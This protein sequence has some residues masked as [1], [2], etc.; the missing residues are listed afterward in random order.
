[1]TKSVEWFDF[2]NEARNL[3]LKGQLIADFHPT[4][5][6]AIEPSVDNSFFLQFVMS[7]D[8][9][10]WYRTTW[11]RLLDAPKFSNPMENLK[12]VGQEIKPTIKFEHGSINKSLL[13]DIITLVPS[14]NIPPVIDEL[15][16]ITI[17]GV[18]YTVI[19]GYGTT[20]ITYKWHQLP[21]KWLQLE[22]L[23][24]LLEELNESLIPV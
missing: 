21:A 9:V 19:I 17:D 16:G 23:I 11:L 18:Y 22:K 12:F 20:Q 7:G 8:K 13:K 1:M 4:I 3:L 15:E 5:Q 10:D 24:I 2:M 14:L 6:L